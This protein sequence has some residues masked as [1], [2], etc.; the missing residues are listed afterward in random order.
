MKTIPQTDDGAIIE[1]LPPAP[2]ES[3]ADLFKFVE[4][5]SRRDGRGP[6]GP[7]RRS[8][9]GVLP[10]PDRDSQSINRRSSELRRVCRT[11]E[12]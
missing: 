1:E 5:R 11:R 8:A 12:I 9:F 10:Y 2:I 6:E 4:L 3:G 7:C